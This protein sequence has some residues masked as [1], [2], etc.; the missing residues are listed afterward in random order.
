MHKRFRE[1]HPSNS[2]QQPA[3]KIHCAREMDCTIQGVVGHSIDPVSSRSPKKEFSWKSAPR[4]IALV[5]GGGI[6]AGRFGHEFR[7]IIIGRV[8]CALSPA[9]VPDR[10]GKY[11]N[12]YRRYY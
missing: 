1:R 6:G 8:L 3:S 7:N 9:H 12:F 4:G 10:K 2:L 11:E 5:G